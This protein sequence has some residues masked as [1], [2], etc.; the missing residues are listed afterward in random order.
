MEELKLE[1]VK[2]DKTKLNNSPPQNKNKNKTKLSWRAVKR[3]QWVKA[4]DAKPENLSSIP[5]AKCLWLLV[6]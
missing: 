5:G 6:C 2:E 4:P 3:T 1:Q